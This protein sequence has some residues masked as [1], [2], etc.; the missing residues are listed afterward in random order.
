MN[1][2]CYRI[3]FEYKTI[4]L[5]VGRGLLTDNIEFWNVEAGVYDL[6]SINTEFFNKLHF[7]SPISDEQINNYLIEINT[8]IYKINKSTRKTLDLYYIGNNKPLQTEIQLFSNSINPDF[9]TFKNWKFEINQIRRY[10]VNEDHYTYYDWNNHILKSRKR[11]HFKEITLFGVTSN[12]FNGTYDPSTSQLIG[13]EVNMGVDVSV[14]YQYRD[15]ISKTID[16]HPLSSTP[17]YIESIQH[18]KLKDIWE[19]NGLVI[20]LSST[21]IPQT[22]N[23]R[24]ELHI[25]PQEIYWRYHKRS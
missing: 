10:L 25:T 19:V 22:E 6:N 8:G 18:L 24:Y 23:M 14:Y 12:K 7:S 17:T 4:K 5:Y 16:Q 11:I 9:H 2:F 1:Y 21:L 3:G 13:L 20:E 15:V